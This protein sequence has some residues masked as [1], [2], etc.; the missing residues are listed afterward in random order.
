MSRNRV[1][2]SGWYPST[3][4]GVQATCARW[5]AELPQETREFVAAI[6]PHAGWS[7][8]GRIAFRTL[9]RLLPD[10]DTVAVV[11]GHLQAGDPVHLAP[12]GSY[13]TPFGLLSADNELADAIRGSVEVVDDVR[14][15]NTVE[16]QLPLVHALYP[17]ANG[18]YLRCAPDASA[19]QLG[20]AVHTY[21][22]ESARRVLVVGSTDLTHYGPAYGF[23]PHGRGEEAVRWAR[24][25]ND[26]RIVEAMRD[27][28]VERTLDLAR[29]ES[30]ACSA[31]AAAA[32][33]RFSRLEGAAEGM[34]VE[35]GQSYDV[36]PDDSFVGYVGMGF[37]PA[38]ST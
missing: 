15:D 28:D 24:E 19:A 22:R 20:E 1:L 2:P 35:Y 37:V 9:R 31:G 6:V 14:P 13:E 3:G 17:D 21:A 36:R 16:V 11:G 4:E 26:G 33:M 8:S 32:A 25:V 12:E 30:A 7:F 10:A 23:V 29:R 5:D 34:L 27:L 18:L 38:Q